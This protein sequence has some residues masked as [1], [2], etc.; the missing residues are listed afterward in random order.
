MLLP[1]YLVINLTF[2][3]YTTS[4][5]PPI[6]IIITYY[7]NKGRN[8]LTRFKFTEVLINAKL[9]SYFLKCALI[10]TNQGFF[11]LLMVLIYCRFHISF[12]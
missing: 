3:L 8:Y 12:D 2:S 9:C 1:V 5:Y 7:K 11:D 4:V 10:N 6:C